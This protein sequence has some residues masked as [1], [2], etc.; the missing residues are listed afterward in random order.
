MQDRVE[1][2]EQ[3]GSAVHEGAR[4][5]VLIPADNGEQPGSEDQ[6][7]ALSVKISRRFTTSLSDDLQ[8]SVN[9]N[10]E[11]TNGNFRL[12]KMNTGIISPLLAVVHSTADLERTTEASWHEKAK[13]LREHMVQSALKQS[14]EALGAIARL[15][16][17]PGNALS[18]SDLQTELARALNSNAWDGNS[19]AF[20]DEGFAIASWMLG[21]DVV[22]F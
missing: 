10:F 22:L 7:L 14:P 4:D 13:K 2:K 5:Q 20:P 3:A 8:W 19:Q 11:I 21:A 18:G 17:E 15:C 1:H 6:Y 16:G 12:V 9:Q